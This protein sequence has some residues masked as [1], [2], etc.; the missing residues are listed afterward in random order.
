MHR[1]MEKDDLRHALPRQERVTC[2]SRVRTRGVL[3][4]KLI[5]IEKTE[6]THKAQCTAGAAPRKDQR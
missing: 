3:Q 6:V 1:M 5:N 4:H 2:S